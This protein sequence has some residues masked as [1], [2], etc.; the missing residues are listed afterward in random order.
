[1]QSSSKRSTVTPLRAAS[2]PWISWH[3]PTVAPYLPACPCTPA[4]CT[5]CAVA[6][7]SFSCTDKCSYSRCAAVPAPL[8]SS[9]KAFEGNKGC[10]RPQA[11][12]PVSTFWCIFSGH[13]GGSGLCSVIDAYAGY[14]KGRSH[15][16]TCMDTT[17]G[18]AAAA[19]LLPLL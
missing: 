14:G 2:T 7:A 10:R 3:Q 16:R 19:A 13:G 18:L 9:R 4:C 6:S 5:F 8:P 12:F 11:V 15:S 17:P 1:M